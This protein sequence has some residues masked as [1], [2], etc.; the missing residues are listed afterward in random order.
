MISNLSASVS[1]STHPHIGTNVQ[2]NVNSQTNLYRQVIHRSWM[3]LHGGRL[4]GA[5]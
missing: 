2:G 5:M 1:A 4:G 3:R